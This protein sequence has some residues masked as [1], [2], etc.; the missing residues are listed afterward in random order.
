[1]TAHP[2]A[3]SCPPANRP[4][5]HIATGNVRLVWEWIWW[6]SSA[7]IWIKRKAERLGDYESISLLSII[8]M[9]FLIPLTIGTL[10]CSIATSAKPSTFLAKI[11]ADCL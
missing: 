11:F 2:T 5:S 6:N 8:M 4:K 7:M 3:N 10:S 1:M 9:H